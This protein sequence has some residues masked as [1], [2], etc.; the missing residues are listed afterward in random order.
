MKTESNDNI[1]TIAAIGLLAY[2]S[3]DIA[4]HVFGHGVACLVLGGRII[5]LTSVFVN[6]SLTGAAIDLAG[7]FANLIVGLIALL[8]MRFTIRASPAVRL[9]CILAAAFNLFWF[10]LQLV[11]SA[12]GKI[13]DWAWPMH[14]FYVSE[15]VR[16]G[17]I[18]TGA[19][20]YL[21][22]VRGIAVFMAAFA[23]PRARATKIVLSAWLTSGAIAC[24]TAAFDHNPGIALRRA[25][26]QSM[27]LS[28]GLLMVPARASQLSGSGPNAAPIG[29]SFAWT[30]AAFVVGT[31]SIL[32]L[33]PGFA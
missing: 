17:L 2:A 5:A 14:R 12:A 27:V 1:G 31:A 21:L 20:G 32:L 25:L 16:Y 18:A 19:L 13:D 29:F 3:S 6:C 9:L 30:A 26:L 24:A 8:A 15:P 4:H 23:T 7:P 33:G 11:S 22:T 10:A 28:I